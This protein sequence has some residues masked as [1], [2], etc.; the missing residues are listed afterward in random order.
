MIK[1]K[2]VYEP[3]SHNDG[4]RILVDR[5]WPRGFARKSLRLD[6]WCR[7][8]APSA[9]LRR[10]FGHDE[11]KWALFLRR[12][13]AELAKS[14]ASWRPLLEAARRGDVTLL[15]AARDPDHNNAVALAEFLRVR[16]DRA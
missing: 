8:A 3:P 16:M 4:A 15:Y 7:D 9:A 10:W 6:D 14:P 1:I 12:Y 5:L 11:R 2:R 13:H